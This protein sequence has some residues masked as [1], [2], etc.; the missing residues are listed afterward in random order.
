M[1]LLESVV[2]RLGEN[3]TLA[4]GA[5]L[6]GLAFGFMAQRSRFCLRSAVI[7]FA[8]NQPGGKLT[9]WLFAFATAVGATQ[10]LAW[11]GLFDASTARQIAARGSLSGAAI[12]GALFGVGMILARGCSSRLLV[13]AAQGNLRSLLSGLVF[14][15]T[16]QAALTGALSPLRITISEWWTIDGGGAR[17]L[18]A[19]TG[20]GHGGAFAF[21]M[22]WLAAAVVW[23][24]RQRVPAWG[25]AGAIGVGLAITA[26]WWLTYAV[27]TVGFDPHPIQSLSFTGP[28]AE[29]LNRVLFV[30]DKPVS[31]DLGLVPGV[32]LGSF[33]AAALFGELR[34]E[35]FQGGASMR[36]Y[37]VGAVCMGF[38]GM[39]AGGCAVGAGLSGAA[40]FTATSW[41]TLCAMWIAAAL[42]DRLV[43]QRATGALDQAVPG[44]DAAHPAT[45]AAA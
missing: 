16:A 9:V 7:E 11:A 19:R 21:A 23:A 1:A 18:I 13:L 42:T 15:V 37:I 34:L 38:G 32:F 22:L 24:R 17:D 44:A 41:V 33:L 27:S 31:F 29:V 5:L 28:S 39:L 6:I 14:A 30:T 4:T 36:R 25:W 8:R 40:V 45:R 20:I 26:A 43:D 12:G 10:A 2:E 35:G 3:G